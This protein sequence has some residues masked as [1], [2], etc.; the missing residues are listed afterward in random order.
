MTLLA[1]NMWLKRIKW[2][3]YSVSWCAQIVR[4]MLLN[5]LWNACW[6]FAWPFILAWLVSG[7]FDFF[8]VRLGGGGHMIWRQSNRQESTTEEFVTVKDFPFYPLTFRSCN[9]CKHNAACQ[10]IPFEQ[11]QLLNEDNSGFCSIMSDS[12]QH[13]IGLVAALAPLGQW[14]SLRRLEH[15]QEVVLLKIPWLNNS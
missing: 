12:L 9:S 6:F 11:I 13:H 8:E 3:L 2:W 14:F 5:K 10:Q 1:I 15:F 7:Q 4:S